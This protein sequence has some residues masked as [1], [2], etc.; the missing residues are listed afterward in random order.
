MC[1]PTSPPVV[2]SECLVKPPANRKHRHNLQCQ[3]GSAEHSGLEPTAGSVRQT[4]REDHGGA[5]LLWNWQRSDNVCKSCSGMLVALM[6]RCVWMVRTS[7][8]G[9]GLIH[10]FLNVAVNATQ[11]LFWRGTISP[12]GP[13]PPPSV[14]RPDAQSRCPRGC[15]ST[16]HIDS[17][18]RLTCCVHI[19]R[20]TLILL[21]LLLPESASAYHLPIKQPLQM[22]MIRSLH[23]IELVWK[24]EPAVHIK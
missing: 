14:S 9:W 24:L 4:L 20:P 18:P 10:F 1:T 11:R 2:W 7:H 6:T 21:P 15:C 8:R 12:P 3:V 17:S 5:A 23:I 16:F 19:C 22:L 13:P